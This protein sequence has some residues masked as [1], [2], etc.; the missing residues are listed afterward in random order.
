MGPNTPSQSLTT[1]INLDDFLDLF[2]ATSSKSFMRFLLVVRLG[3]PKSRFSSSFKSGV[4]IASRDKILSL[5]SINRANNLLSITNLIIKW[6]S[7]RLND[8]FRSIEKHS[9]EQFN[10]S[11]ISEKQ[12]NNSFFNTNPSHPIICLYT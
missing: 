5:W 11:F 1:L 8:K 12:F 3:E 10:N 9:L 7:R 2:T 6:N 4:E